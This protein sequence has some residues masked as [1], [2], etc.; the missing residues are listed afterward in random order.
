MV[1]K[2]K[3]ITE[4]L[5]RVTLSEGIKLTPE[6]IEV[7][8][9]LKEGEYKAGSQIPHEDF[10]L[11]FNAIYDSDGCFMDKSDSVLDDDYGKTIDVQECYCGYSAKKDLFFMAYEGSLKVVDEDDEYGDVDWESF[12][13]VLKSSFNTKALTWSK[14]ELVN[15]YVSMFYSA[16]YKRL[17]QE[18]PDLVGIRLD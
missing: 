18:Y 3:Q 11:I 15:T 9:K 4:A 12:S 5:K 8:R 1:S 10:M 7:F 6:A 2:V 14:P 16:P 17:K 13:C